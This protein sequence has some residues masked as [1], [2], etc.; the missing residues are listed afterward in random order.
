MEPNDDNR[1][2]YD[3]QRFTWK[4][5]PDWPPQ[6]YSWRLVRRGRGDVLPCHDRHDPCNG[7]RI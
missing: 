7:G 3:L 4:T 6:L 5:T 2:K 1:N